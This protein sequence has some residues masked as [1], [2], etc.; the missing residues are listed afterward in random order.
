MDDASDR[1]SEAGG[2]VE[3]TG[4]AGL[5]LFSLAL[6]GPDGPPEDALGRHGWGFPCV[7]DDGS[8]PWGQ[9]VS[10]IR[11][12]V[13]IPPPNMLLSREDMQALA[14]GY[15]PIDM[16]D[17]WLAF[18]EDNR[19]FL[20]RS[21]TGYGIYEVTFAAKETGFVVT[22]A[23]IESDPERGR[24]DFD[25]DN[26]D[27]IRERDELRDLIVHVSGEP[28]PPL[29][30][31]IV[32]RQPVLEVVLGDITTQ[33]VDAVVNSAN[34]ALSD[35]QGVNGAIHRRAGPE[36]LAHCMTLESCCVGDAVVTPGFGLAAEWVIHTVAP[37]W[38]DGTDGEP[39]LLWACYQACLSYAD[40]VGAESVAFPALGA[41]ARGFPPEAAAEIAVAAV[42]GASTLI[43]N[44]RFVC[45]DPHTAS[46]FESAIDEEC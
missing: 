25:P 26:F 17:K 42:R 7:E 24:G 3:G 33:E 23:R 18:M 40:E 19:L 38:H 37:R 29:L 45:L 6:W 13:G 21:W 46:S 44:I 5:S 32:S 11:Q 41:G 10:P 1:G 20:H 35:G 31:T 30:P 39:L 12:P 28:M 27:P 15:A 43:R 36:L 4:G 14:K 8:G 16:N 9:S 34:K 2:G 22:S